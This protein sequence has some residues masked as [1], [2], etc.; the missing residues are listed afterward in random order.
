MSIQV[1]APAARHGNNDE[2]EQKH[3]KGGEEQ[4][5]VES[6]PAS[7]LY[8]SF[9]GHAVIRCAQRH[10][11]HIGKEVRVSLR[12]C[13]CFLRAVDNLYAKERPL[14]SIFCVHGEQLP[15]REAAWLDGE[16]ER[17]RLASVARFLDN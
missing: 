16:V 9:L 17:K 11:G 3:K 10:D 5:I 4:L 2:H 1:A 14:L 12:I 15:V 8:G 7:K 13:L 6:R